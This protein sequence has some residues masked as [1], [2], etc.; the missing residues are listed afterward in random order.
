M[1]WTGLLTLD[2]SAKYSLS[3]SLEVGAAVGFCV[4]SALTIVTLIYSILLVLTGTNL[5]KQL[6]R[7]FVLCTGA[8]VVPLVLHAIMSFFLD[9]LMDATSYENGG[10]Q[11]EIISSIFFLAPSVG[12]II[13]LV[14]GQWLYRKIRKS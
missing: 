4:W 2:S 5:S 6:W 9:S 10:K 7:L 13:G 8:T 1:T 14:L 12:V 3:F 11:S